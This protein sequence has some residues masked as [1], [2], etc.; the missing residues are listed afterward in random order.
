[1]FSL[2]GWGVVD[3][4]DEVV[5]LFFKVENVEEKDEVWFVIV[6]CLNVGKSLF[7]NVFMGE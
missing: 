5:I 2:Y 4:F 1:M 3:L 7:V 6:G